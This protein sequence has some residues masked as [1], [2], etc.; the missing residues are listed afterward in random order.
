MHKVIVLGTY[1]VH[2]KS[3]YSI[4]LMR[5]LTVLGLMPE[6][7]V[8]KTSKEAVRGFPLNK[9]KIIARGRKGL[10]PHRRVLQTNDFNDPEC[11]Q[12]VAELK[13]DLLL[14]AGGRDILR[15]PILQ[16]AK[17]GC[18]GGHYGHLPEIRGMGTVE[19]SVLQ[20]IPP[21]VAIQRINPGIDTGEVLM[22]AQVTIC[23]NDSFTVIR[24]RSYFMTKIMLA[25]AAQ[26]LLNRTLKPQSQ[27]LSRGQQYYR[28]HPFIR[29]LAEKKLTQQF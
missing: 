9:I 2:P 13:P 3:M 6:C 17:H 25:F 12:R 23:Q 16:V 14:Y 4:D 21:T 19:W 15:A 7:I 5:H 11:V 24:E 20:D 29:A 28:Q 26:G 10:I 8:F 22:Q 18:L 27:D 1:D